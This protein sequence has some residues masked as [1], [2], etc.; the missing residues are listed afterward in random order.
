MGSK[1][2]WA[3]IQPIIKRI[4]L[5]NLRNKRLIL[6]IILYL[7]KQ[8]IGIRNKGCDIVNN[9]GKNI[10]HLVS[11]YNILKN[12]ISID[13]LPICVFDGK[14][15]ELKKQ[16]II[17]RKT[18]TEKSKIMV[19]IIG[20][21]ITKINEDW[22]EINSLDTDVIKPYMQYLSSEELEIEDMDYNTKLNI[23]Y[24]KHFKKSYN[25]NSSQINECKHMLE[26]MGIPVITSI[27]EADKDSANLFNKLKQYISGI[28]TE[29]SDI[30]LYGGEC[31]YKDI[32]FATGTISEINI[33]DVLKYLQEKTNKIDQNI[34]FTF[35]NL[36]DFSIILGNDYTAGIR[37]NSMIENYENIDKSISNLS[38]SRE[39]IFKHFIKSKCDIQVFI[40]NLYKLNELYNAIIYYVPT[41][42]KETYILVRNIY[43]SSSSNNYAIKDICMKQPDLIKLQKYLVDNNIIKKYS[44]NVLMKNLSKL[45][46]TFK[47]K[48][49]KRI[50]LKQP[51]T[52]S[53]GESESSNESMNTN[54]SIDNNDGWTLVVKHKSKLIY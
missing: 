9:R 47:I 18:N 28:L 24:I 30:L 43:T 37:T 51:S 7:H 53:S 35:E 34:K 3:F 12:L 21:E 45:Y 54:C 33:K 40:N 25:I 50:L 8:I 17:K 27:E 32:D 16:T 13:I 46:E 15:P 39:I 41:N 31:I 2:L 11:L 36:I 4:P 23:E 44:I 38:N 52:D 14:P 48:T 5:D 26:L 29:D 22:D 6:D 10:N 49:K 19:N 42:F 1:G 20:E